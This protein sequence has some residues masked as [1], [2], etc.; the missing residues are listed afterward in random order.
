VTAGAVVGPERTAVSVARCRPVYP[1]GYFG[2]NTAPNSLE[3]MPILPR[4]YVP[5]RSYA[6]PAN[7]LST[8]VAPLGYACR[9]DICVRFPTG[10]AL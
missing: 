4:I 2:V 3:I 10:L 7:D 5:E 9:T 6:P 1:R 8:T